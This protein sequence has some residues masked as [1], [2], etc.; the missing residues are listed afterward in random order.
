MAFIDW[1][2]SL[3]VG[4]NQIDTQHKKLIDLV[5]RLHGAMGQGQATQVL[6]ATLKELVTY[7]R[8]HFSTEERLMSGHGYPD[9]AA[10]KKEHDDLTGQ[11]SQLLAEF[12]SGKTMISIKVMNFL[13]N[14]LTKRIAGTDKK[15]APFLKS[16]GVR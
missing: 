1:N 6:G 4:L 2:Q 10:H 5:N 8:T 3:S 14:W 15:Y 16:K 13:K 9:F 7:T 11:V 12:E